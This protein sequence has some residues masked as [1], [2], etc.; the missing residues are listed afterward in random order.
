MG[1]DLDLT[2]LVDGLKEAVEYLR[3]L[4]GRKIAIRVPAME[5]Q[6]DVWTKGERYVV[7]SEEWFVH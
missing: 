5:W 3:G 1:H 7:P 6:A 4:R 2:D